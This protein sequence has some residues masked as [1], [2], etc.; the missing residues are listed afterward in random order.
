M[1]MQFIV[2]LQTKGKWGEWK[3]ASTTAYKPVNMQERAGKTTFKA[4]NEQEG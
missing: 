2:R 3:C 4:H 1:T